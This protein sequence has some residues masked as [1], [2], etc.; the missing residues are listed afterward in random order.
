MLRVPLT[1]RSTD[2]RQA[3]AEPC[4]SG[5]IASTFEG[6]VMNDLKLLLSMLG[7]TRGKRSAATCQPTCGAVGKA[8]AT[9]M[10][11]CDNVEPNPA[12]GKVYVACTNN[13]KRGAGSSAVADEVNPCTE[14]REGHVVATR[15]RTRKLISA[16]SRRTRSAAFAAR[17]TWRSIRRAIHGSPPTAHL[18]SSAATTAC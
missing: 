1:S 17:T 3:G 16:A 12:T 2:A 9:K 8:G 14:N 7:H 4:H 18:G 15:P 6:F 5:C 13:T 10:D 11:R